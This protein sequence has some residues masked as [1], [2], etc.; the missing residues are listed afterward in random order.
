MPH[1]WTTFP[2][3]QGVCQQPGEPHQ[4]QHSHSSQGA[5]QEKQDRPVQTKDA[6]DYYQTI[7][8]PFKCDK[9]F[10]EPVNLMIHRLIELDKYLKKREGKDTLRWF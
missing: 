3:K 7:K 10:N 9:D 6:C 5:C 8:F 2:S 4:Q 1:R